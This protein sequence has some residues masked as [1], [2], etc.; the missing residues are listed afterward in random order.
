MDFTFIPTNGMLTFS[1]NILAAHF[2]SVDLIILPAGMRYC[3]KLVKRGVSTYQPRSHTDSKYQ[4]IPLRCMAA[5]VCLHTP[6]PDVVFKKSRATG[7]C[8]T[9]KTDQSG[10]TC[11]WLQI[12]FWVKGETD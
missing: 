4:Q 1:L 7:G 11:S 2:L 8:L 9:L 3:D 12:A 5:P 6:T 10:V